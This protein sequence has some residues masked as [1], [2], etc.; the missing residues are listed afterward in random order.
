MPRV[1]VTKGSPTNILILGKIEYCKV[2][3]M[4]CLLL[5]YC[6]IF[7]VSLAN[8]NCVR[9]DLLILKLMAPLNK[10]LAFKVAL[11]LAVSA[12]LIACAIG[13]VGT[14]VAKVE[15]NG[16]TA[17]IELHSV[18]LHLRT[19][20][21]DLGGQFGYSRRTYVFVSDDTVDAGWYFLHV[22]SPQLDAVAQDL[23]TVGIEFS[24]VA[25]LAGITLGY[26]HNRLHAR[27]SADES[28]YIEYAGSG[29]RVVSSQYCREEEPCEIAVPSR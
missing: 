13:N 2:E 8:R 28:V 22:P 12:G 18:G 24:G 17:V 15:R 10:R 6:R 11:L 7:C 26:S 19:R 29:T 4:V 21:D 27:V 16:D 23:M 1:D 5:S 3:N 25:P 9:I 20:S 14:L